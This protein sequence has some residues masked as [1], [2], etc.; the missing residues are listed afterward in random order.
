MIVRAS[1]KPRRYMPLAKWKIDAPWT[2]VLSRSKN[3]AASGSGS[4]RSPA[5]DGSAVELDGP[6]PC[7]RDS[8]AIG[9]DGAGRGTVSA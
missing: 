2:I 3:A 9:E 7:G 4:I 6:A 8:G 5:P 1:K